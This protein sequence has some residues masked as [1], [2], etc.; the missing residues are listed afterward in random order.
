MKTADPDQIS[1]DE[2]E[3]QSNSNP[4]MI[5]DP[6]S[7]QQA[8]VEKAVKNVYEY[9]D[10][11]VETHAGA[12]AD[13]QEENEKLREQLDEARKQREELKEVTEIIIEWL[14]NEGVLNED[15]GLQWDHFDQSPFVG[16]GGSS[17]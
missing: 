1:R 10:G 15:P 8:K 16:D 2:A 12:L 3:S 11:A 6:V 17:Q 13:L 9:T 7:G 4:D 5:R 14:V